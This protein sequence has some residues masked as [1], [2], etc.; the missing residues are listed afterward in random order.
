MC[1]FIINIC[2]PFLF[3]SPHFSEKERWDGE[4]LDAFCEFA[5]F[6]G[7]RL[8]Y[9]NWSVCLF[10]CFFPTNC[11]NM[12]NS[13]KSWDVYSRKKHKLMSYLQFLYIYGLENINKSLKCIFLSLETNVREEGD[14]KSLI[15]STEP[16]KECVRVECSLFHREPQNQPCCTLRSSPDPE[17]G[18][19]WR[20]RPPML[21]HGCPPEDPHRRR[22]S[23]V[24][25]LSSWS[26]VQLRLPLSADS[27]RGRGGRLL[28]PRCH[29][30]TPRCT[31]RRH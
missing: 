15:C 10:S 21:P 25:C 8:C 23:T 7:G 12:E 3:F 2:F 27:G 29:R 18:V 9:A 16:W 20:G 22:A 11:S 26:L 5:D 28:A 17:L 31:W 24:E 14:F 19:C 30:V 6:S 4:V 13:R 1:Y